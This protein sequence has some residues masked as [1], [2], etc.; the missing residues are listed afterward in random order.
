MMKRVLLFGCA[1]CAAFGAM[2]AQAT[3]IIDIYD[4][5]GDGTYGGGQYVNGDLNPGDSGYNRFGAGFIASS[6]SFF[7]GIKVAAGYTYDRLDTGAYNVGL[8]A[9]NGSGMPSLAAPLAFTSLTTTTP[10][11]TT[12]TTL[13]TWNYTGP[14]VW[15]N[16][17]SRYWLIFTPGADTTQVALGI[18]HNFTGEQI[19][20]RGDINSMWV[21]ATPIALSV[22]GTAVP[23]P[24]TWA[25]FGLGAGM[26]GFV[27]L[28]RSV[29]RS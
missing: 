14:Y 8:Y 5:L 24:A 22:Q 28:R 26:V 21:E 2:R 18:P 15:L 7:A 20:L 11:F 17:G 19:V 10:A 25:L 3:P 9:D 23:E 13:E 16:G 27:R 12:D 4:A 29:R 1:L 6:T